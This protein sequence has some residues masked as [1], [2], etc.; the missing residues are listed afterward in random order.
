MKVQLIGLGRMGLGVGSRLSTVSEVHGFDLDEKSRKAATSKNI[1]T[2]TTLEQLCATSSPGQHC[3]WL[4]VPAGEA[5]DKVINQLLP[6]LS[7][8]DIVIDGGN[9]HYKDSI[10]RAQTLAAKAVAYLDVGTS[11]GIK[12]ETEG[13]CLMVGGEKKT[14]EK[15][16][17]LFTA[18]AT[19]DGFSYVGPSGAGHYVKMVHNAIEYGMLQVLGEGFWLLNKGGYDLDLPKIANLWNHGSV[20]RSWLVELVGDVF[21]KQDF[22]KL[23]DQIGGGETGRW[24]V[25]EAMEKKIPIPLITQALTE[26][27]AS[28]Q[29][30]NF[31]HQI[32]AGLRFAFGGH[33]TTSK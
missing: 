31:G 5:V 14:F 32:I 6:T 12:G 13:F 9:S 26:R 28:S 1:K 7:A 3:Y 30:E 21:K 18:V 22:S 23:G 20:I 29:G 10:R 19:T 27:Y 24:A 25:L 4:L 17:P 2:C 33:E 11:G 15:L 8:G 16:S